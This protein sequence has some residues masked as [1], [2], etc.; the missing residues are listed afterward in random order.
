MYLCKST[1][2][3]YVNVG[4]DWIPGQAWESAQNKLCS[5]DN[6]TIVQKFMTSYFISVKIGILTVKMLG[7]F[8][9]TFVFM[10]KNEQ[11][12]YINANSVF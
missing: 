2:Q 6:C 5:Q 11:L 4:L 8:L 3:G 10:R 1:W 12:L 7:A 9:L